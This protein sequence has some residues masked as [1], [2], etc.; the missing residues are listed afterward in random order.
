MQLVELFSLEATLNGA[1]IS[2]NKQIL[3]Q[4]CQLAAL[5]DP[6]LNTKEAFQS[7]FNREKLGSTSIGR[8][9]AIPHGTIKNLS[10]PVGAILHLK[11]PVDYNATDGQPVDLFFMFLTPNNLKE[12]QQQDL[13]T[14]LAEQLRTPLIGEQLRNATDEAS[15]LQILVG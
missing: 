15:L 10:K 3:E 5:H 6:T 4:L 12:E 2:S 13:L 1:E 9:I 7:L 14:L 8:G 11:E